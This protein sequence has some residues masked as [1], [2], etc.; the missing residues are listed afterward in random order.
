MT[1]VRVLVV[2]DSATMRSLIIESLRQDPGVEVVGQAGDPLEARDTIKLLNPD[3]ITL[4]VEMPKMNGL[5]FLEKIMRLRPTPVIMVS[6]QTSLGTSTAIRALEIG[7]VDCVAKPSPQDRHTFDELAAK[8]KAAAHAH[9]HRYSR[10]IEPMKDFKAT[11]PVANAFKS[12]GKLI[13][14]GSST[15]GVEALIKIISQFPADCP[16]TVITQHMPRLFTKSLAARMDRIC[17]P[18]V[19]EAAEGAPLVPGHVYIAPAGDTHL[20]VGRS[21]K[22]LK[23]HLRL[24]DAVNG[25]RPSVDVLFAS[26]AKY[27]GPDAIGVILTGM[28]RDG[29]ASLLAM[30]EAGARTLGQDEATCVVYGMPKVAFEIGAVQKQVSLD[31]MGREILDATKMSLEGVS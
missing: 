2:D 4:D 13:A 30:R 17:A 20:E 3:V 21:G 14:I 5:D 15:G 18:Q 16:P 26:V 12:N 19:S 24:G 22:S 9:V 23:C 7:A 31:K 11:G 29:A 27:V 28:G 25:H 1:P 8:V 6:N 10:G